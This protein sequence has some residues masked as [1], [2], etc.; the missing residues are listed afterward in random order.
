M[1]E[2]TVRVRDVKSKQTVTM[3]ARELAPGMVQAEIVDTTGRVAERVWVDTADVM[4]GPIRHPPLT[5]L[6]PIFEWFS[7]LFTTAFPKT[8]GEW[9][10]GFRVDVNYAKEILL[11]LHVAE[12]F[13]D[14]TAGRPRNDY[15]EKE[16]LQFLLACLNSGP[17]TARLVTVRVAL[18]DK[19]AREAAARWGHTTDDD[20]LAAQKL[21]VQ[22]H[23][24]HPGVVMSGELNDELAAILKR[25]I[26]RRLSGPP[27]E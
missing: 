26:A 3:P 9:E 1:V 27:A 24:G 20:I 25:F 21:L 17:E 16:L 19:G 12:V 4:D 10:D 11:W 22:W 23:G 5:E 18:T 13:E 15:R 6:R 14:M 8:P 7:R 2:R